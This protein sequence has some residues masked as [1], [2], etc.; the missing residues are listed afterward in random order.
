[1]NSFFDAQH[2]AR[3]KQARQAQGLN[4]IPDASLLRPNHP[5]ARATLRHRGSGEDWAVTAIR[6]DWLLGRFLVASL[7]SN[8]RTR[9][10]VVETISSENPEIFRQLD[11]FI[12]EFEVLTH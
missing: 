5:L 6:E 4:R 1:M 9:T 10:C 7:E 3:V 8:G 11:S 12:A 2:W